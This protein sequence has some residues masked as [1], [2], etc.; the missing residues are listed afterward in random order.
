MRPKRVLTAVTFAALAFA[1]AGCGAVQVQPTT[2]AGSKTLASRG[3]VDSP[4]KMKNHLTCL[5]DAHLPV[6]VLSSTQL[7]IGGASSGPT[8]FFTPTPGAAQA[9]QIGGKAQ[10]AEVIGSAL[11][12]PHQ[13][14]DGEMA[15]IGACLA[16][17]V[18]G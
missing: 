4:V 2:P 13:G 1:A 12:Y 8:I 15:T 14:S 17:G 16:Q 10:A 11:V 7:R 3:Q 5:R 18:Q 9:D 6:Q